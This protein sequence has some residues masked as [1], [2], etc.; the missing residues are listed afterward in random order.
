MKATK[1]LAWIWLLLLPA[2]GGSLGY[3]FLGY[4]G[5]WQAGG[6]GFG[7]FSGWALGGESWGGPGDTG[8]AFLVGPWL[9]VHP[10]FHLLP[11]L[12]FGGESRAGG[13]FFLDLG[14]RGFLLPEEGGWLFGLGV[15]YALPLGFPGGGWYLRLLVGGGRP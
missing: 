8:G 3:G 4:Q 7:A 9:E 12:G 6:G 14:A 15:G 2:F 11:T 13:G 1:A 10:G 5:G